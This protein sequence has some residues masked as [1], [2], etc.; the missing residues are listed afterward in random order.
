MPALKIAAPAP[1]PREE[2]VLAAAGTFTGLWALTWLGASAGAAGAAIQGGFAVGGVMAA[3][4]LTLLWWKTRAIKELH[5]AAQEE[6]AHAAAEGEGKD[7]EYE[8]R[9]DG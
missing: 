7:P 8:T 6:D 4:G 3:S 2:K 5:D 1:M 9:V